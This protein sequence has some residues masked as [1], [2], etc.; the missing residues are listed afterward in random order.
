MLLQ[1]FQ[2]AAREPSASRWKRQARDPAVR[3]PARFSSSTSCREQ[4]TGRSTCSRPALEAEAPLGLYSY[5]PDPASERFPL[6][7]ISPASDKTI[8]SMMGELPRPA[9][10]LL[11]NP[12][13]APLA[14]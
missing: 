8:S 13:D 4:S 11:M 7:L 1:H 2:G 9:V 14:A 10:A 5:Q 12:A 6:A 3:L